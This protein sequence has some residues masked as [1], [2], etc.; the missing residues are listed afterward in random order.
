MNLKFRSP[1]FFFALFSAV[2][3]LVPQALASNPIAKISEYQGEVIVQSGQNIFSVKQVGQVLNEG[4]RIQTQQGEVQITFD[5]GALMKVRPFSNVLIQERQEKSGFWLF[6]TERVVRR[7]TCFV[8]KL[9]FKSGSSK[10]EN[11]LQTPTVVC[12]LRGSDGDIGFDPASM[13][14]YLN[15]YSGDAE[16]VGKVIRGLFMDMG[17]EAFAKS[18]VAQALAKAYQA[19]READKT[20][21]PKDQINARGDA[22]AVVKLAALELQNNPDKN[23]QKE[24]QVAANYCG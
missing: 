11:F 23:I 12:G 9:W 18:P 13:E 14:S 7:I 4:D 16:V 10:R 6:K 24:A 3:F 17:A 20:G 15:M 2:L 5:D 21:S 19:T 22:F 1:L 8:G